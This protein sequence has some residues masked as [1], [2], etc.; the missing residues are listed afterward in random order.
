MILLLIVLIT[1]GV[2]WSFLGSQGEDRTMKEFCELECRQN[3]K[4]KYKFCC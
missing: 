1:T 4:S 2:I 3:I